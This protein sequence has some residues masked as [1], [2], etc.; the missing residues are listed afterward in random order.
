MYSI[1]IEVYFG[2]G[3]IHAAGRIVD[4][5]I[6]VFVC[7]GLLAEPVAVVPDTSER[8][9]QAR[10]QLI[11]GKRL[12]QIIVRSA[13]SAET[14]SKSSLRAETTMIG[15]LLH[16]RIFFIISTPSISGRPRSSRTTSGLHDS[17][18]P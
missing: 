17:A 15:I 14:L 13:S 11:Y 2:V 7:A 3:Y 6:A 16:E 8:N 18:P 9:A 12:C 5:H 1:H 10:K 4:T